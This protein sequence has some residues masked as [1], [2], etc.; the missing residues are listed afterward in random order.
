[1]NPAEVVKHEVE[2]NRRPMVLDFLAEGVRQARQ[3]AA[4]HPKRMILLLKV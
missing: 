1:M 4:V 3:A 2:R